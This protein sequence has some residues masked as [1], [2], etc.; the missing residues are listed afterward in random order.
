MTTTIPSSFASRTLFSFAMICAFLSI[1]VH[2]FSYTPPKVPPI[3]VATGLKNQIYQWRGT[4]QIRYQVDGPLD[5]KPVVLVHGLFVN[6]DHWRKTIK[7]LAKEGYRAFALDLW[8]C[9]YSACP[10][11][12]SEEAQSFNGEA[13]FL[14]ADDDTIIL[15]NIELGTASGKKV[16]IRNVE[17]KHPL[18][19]PYN[20]YTWSELINDFCRD[21]VVPDASPNEQVTLVCNS[22]GTMSSLQAVIDNPDLY[23]GVFCI[24]PNFREL[25]SAEVALANVSMPVLRFVQ[26]QLREKGQGLFDALA[27]PDT[28]KEI[29]KTPYAVRSAVD[30]TLVQV[31]LDPLLLEGASNVV[32]DMLSYSA[33]PL[34]EQQLASF[35]ENK[36]VWV[37][38]GK[39]D[40]WT[41]P[42]R[43]EALITKPPVEKVIGWEGVGHCPHDEAPEK[44]NPEIFDFLNRL[45]Q[46]KSEES[47]EDRVPFFVDT[48]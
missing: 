37:S 28:V 1:Q 46:G 47:V 12:D 34:P 15:K 19:S 7:A 43:V 8:G 38:Y 41:P 48:K 40:P 26:K 33:G 6:S 3:S 22:I 32:F 5:G 45:Y 27:K 18:G 25:H 35:P 4:Q 31:L 21:V 20:F 42:G 39:Q 29:L 30:D 17:L 9:G 23:N 16:R 10:P 14:D 13:R 24:A 11:R 36:P 44:V 2:G